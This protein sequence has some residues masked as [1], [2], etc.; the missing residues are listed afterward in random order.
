MLAK[1]I[2]VCLQKSCFIKTACTQIILQFSN[3]ECESY[4]WTI[5]WSELTNDGSSFANA[6]A[7]ALLDTATCLDV[8]Y[9]PQ[10]IAR[11]INE[12]YVW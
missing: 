3:I 9:V 12:E 8:T 4:N 2:Y 10:G 1:K 11:V 7:I 5:V 6:H